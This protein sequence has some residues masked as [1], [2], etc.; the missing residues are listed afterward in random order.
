MK[1]VRLA[2]ALAAA[3]L[4]STAAGS[5]AQAQVGCGGYGYGCIDIGRLYSVLAQNVP[6]YAA[7]PPVYYSGPVPR[8]YGYS[9]FAYPPGYETPEIVETIMP[10]EISNPFVPSSSDTQQPSGDTV[11][12]ARAPKPLVVMNPFVLGDS[13]SARLASTPK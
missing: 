8:A 6:Y 5:A 13:G 9:P 12:H 3:V 2:A 1:S 4:I 7:F 10:Q 11:T